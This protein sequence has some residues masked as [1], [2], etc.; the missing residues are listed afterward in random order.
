MK[1]HVRTI[2]AR[3]TYQYR[4]RPYHNWV[5]VLAMLSLLRNHR[6][7]V[8]DYRA[9]LVAIAFH[10]AVY[11]SKAK[12]NEARSADLADDWLSGVVSPAFLAAVRSLVMVTM[13]HV[14]PAGVPETVAADMRLLIDLDLSI[15]GS[16]PSAFAVY[17]RAVRQEYSWVPDDAWKTGRRAVL[18]GF[19]SRPRIFLTDT[20]GERLE[21]QAR[22]NIRQALSELEG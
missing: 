21:M 15:L 20:M 1:G 13:K 6:H 9:M 8:N 22:A 2:L 17:D 10:D 19:I 4:G 18:E 7:L 12:D 11:D 3:L 14:V 5:H 16:E